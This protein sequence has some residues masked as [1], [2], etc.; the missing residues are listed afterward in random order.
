MGIRQLQPHAGLAWNRFDHADADHR[1][2]PGQ[3][4]RKADDLAALHSHGRL[5]LVA[6]DH[7]PRVGRQY[8]H[9]DPKIAELLL[10]EARGVLKRLRGKPLDAGRCFVE[11]VERRQR[12]V[13]QVLEKL[14]LLFLLHAHRFRDLD[15]R[16][17][18]PDRLVF[19][20]EFHSFFL[21][22]CLPLLG[23]NLA[24]LA[25][26]PALPAIARKTVRP[27]QPGADHLHHRQPGHAGEKGETDRAQGKQDQRRPGKP[28]RRAEPPRGLHADHPAGTGTLRQRSLERMETQRLDPAA[29]DQQHCK[30][31]ECDHERP[32]VADR[33]AV[34]T[35]ITPED[36]VNQQH[37]PPVRGHAEHVQQN[38]GEPRAGTAAGITNLKASDRMGPAW[39]GA[40][41]G[42]QHQREIG[43]R[44]DQN[45]PSR[46]TQ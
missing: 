46:F 26:L 24:C 19:D 5:D 27:F 9:L 23:G 11:Q 6:R 21:D 37:H 32:A 42:K 17:L 43:G 36:R 7:R 30:A 1:K 14:N 22:Y 35:P 34:Q 2:R 28:E 41:E 38:V 8:L 39:I 45:E 25:V 10:D 13:G 29:G 16:R 15:H 31:C 4:L 44:R 12:C 40:V 18:D 20:Y 33:T 3:I